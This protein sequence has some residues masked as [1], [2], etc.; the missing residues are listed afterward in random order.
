MPCVHGPKK[1]EKKKLTNY[2][3][4]PKYPSSS[5]LIVERTAEWM[6]EP[7]FAKEKERKKKDEL[8]YLIWEYFF[9]ACTEMFSSTET[10]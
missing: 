10:H 3:A 9:G 5:F 7:S 4:P 8:V 2:L 6:S 1:K